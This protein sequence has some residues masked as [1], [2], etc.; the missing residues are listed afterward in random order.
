MKNRLPGF[1][2]WPI[3][4]LLWF[5]STPSLAG[6]TADQTASTSVDI[7]LEISPANQASEPAQ[8]ALLLHYEPLHGGLREG[9]TNPSLTIYQDGYIRVFYPTYMKQEGTYVAHLSSAG[10]EKLWQ[11]LIDPRLLQFDSQK[12]RNEMYFQERSRSER[13]STR[14][15]KSDE[16]TAVVEFY[17]NRGSPHST[18]IPGKP[19]EKKTISWYGLKTDAMRY[20]TVAEI[21]LLYEICEQLDAIMRSDQL[22]KIP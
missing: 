22:S 7:L 5:L 20:T 1:N 19:D 14:Q 17:P 16:V 12:I 18:A 6:L 10:L 4:L 11:K 3:C 9:M 21:Q 8:S 13:P 15:G 2:F